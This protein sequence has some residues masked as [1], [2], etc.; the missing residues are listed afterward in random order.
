MTNTASEQSVQTRDWPEPE[1]G[2]RR[3]VPA[4][5]T[6]VD[7]GRIESLLAAEWE[8]FTA[9]TPASGEHNARAS[10]TLPL[11]VTSSFQ[12]WD[13]YP[14]SIVSA[15]GAWLTDVDGRRLLDLSMG[16]GA[17]LVGHLNP[18]VVQRVTHALEETG[19]L[20]V[21]P[22]P[23]A[24]EVAERFKAR[25]GLGMLRF[26]NSGTESL[27]YAVRSARA[28]TGRK[29]IIKIEG[30]YHG[31]Y[32]A[33][34]VSVKPA[35]E[36]I[37]PAE[38][39]I[40]DVPFDVEAGTVYVTPYNDLPYLTRLLEEHASEVAAV[41]MEPVVENLS[42]VLPDAG[43]LAGVRAACDAH[44]VLLIFDEVKTGL[45]AGYAG[46]SQRLGVKPDLVTLAKS[47]G[48]G[49]PLAAFGGTDEV[50]QVVVDGRMAHFGTYNGNPLVMAAASAVDELCTHEAL[51]A[52][53]AV[54][55][56]ALTAIDAVIA[57]YELPAHTVGFGA[58]GC[59]TWS[60]RPVRNYRDY[61]ATD[62]GVAELSWLWGVNR[63]V[64]TP[65]GL[66][67]QWLVSLAHTDADMD[68]LVGE[69]TDLAKALRG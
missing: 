46:A 7:R 53:E 27:M 8:R 3:W 33:L 56:H 43:Y 37:G 55:V 12:H 54:N 66:D 69:F 32:D 58:K 40:P 68:T 38:A 39:P 50:M 36:D 26:T 15:R 21:T 6:P 20:F 29:A 42:I 11:G 62:F 28:Y 44:G 48:G 2:T 47:I 45:T 22:S 18:L 35:L 4:T 63:G 57:E 59:V 30:G 60:T 10:T 51:D 9:G 31:G 67:E 61:K 41:V 13:P 23:T 1:Q 34:Q 5:S 19:T 16:F 14:V 49:L 52:A 17:M 25:F 64:L 24:T 65:P